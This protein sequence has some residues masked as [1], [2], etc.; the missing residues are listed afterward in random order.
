MGLNKPTIATNTGERQSGQ[1]S[2]MLERESQLKVV[3]P[4]NRAPLAR[5]TDPLSS[6]LAADEFTRSGRRGAQKRALLTWLRGQL[7]PMTSAEIALA[8]GLDRHGVARRLPD[9]ERD[10]SVVRC[11]MRECGA[12]GRP[13]ITW[14]AS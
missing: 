2:L 7:Q 4:A 10:G 5:S 11:A 8:S 3:R 14:R 12:T 6:H 9:C 13:A 1:L